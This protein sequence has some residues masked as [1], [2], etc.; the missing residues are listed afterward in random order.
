M[1]VLWVVARDAALQQHHT[2]KSQPR[3]GGCG[4][5]NMIGLDSSRGDHGVRIFGE[6]LS[7]QEFEFASLVAAGGQSGTV[8]PL[9]VQTR[10]AQ[11]FTETGKWL[12]WRGLMTDSN[13]REAC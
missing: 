9:D 10:P 7:K 13:S 4:L 1:F 12:Q 8:V 11:P 5:T 2:M 3:C 6:C